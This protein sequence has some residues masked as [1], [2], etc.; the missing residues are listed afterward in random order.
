MFNLLIFSSNKL[1]I[2]LSLKLI[3]TINIRFHRGGNDVRVGTESVVDV[4]V[5]LHLHVHLAHVVGTLADGLDGKLL[6]GHF[7][8]DDGL[9]G[10]DGGIG[11]LFPALARDASPEEKVSHRAV[12]ELLGLRI[13]LKTR[14]ELLGDNSQTENLTE[15]SCHTEW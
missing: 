9:Q 12:C 15:R 5:V 6:Q 11:E 8:T 10:T 13:E 1:F 7:T 14:I 3:Y 2:F 4:A